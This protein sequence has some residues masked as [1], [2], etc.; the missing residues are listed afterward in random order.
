MNKIKSCE[1]KKKKVQK[2][3]KKIEKK[4]PLKQVKVRKF[5]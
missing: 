5:C 2:L 3:I 4:G 1:N